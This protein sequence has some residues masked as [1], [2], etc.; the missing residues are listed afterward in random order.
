MY[1]SETSAVRDLLAPYCAG[2]GLDLGYG[3]DPIVPHA[4]AL[5]KLNG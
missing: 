5:R 3:G 4:I 2:D 1:N